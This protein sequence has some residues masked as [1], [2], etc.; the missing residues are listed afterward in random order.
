LGSAVVS[1]D[2]LFCGKR[3]QKTTADPTSKQKS[4]GTLLTPAGTLLTPAGTLLTTAGI[5]LTPTA[6]KSL[7][8]HYGRQSNLISGFLREGDAGLRHDVRLERKE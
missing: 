4:A 7:L 2:F 5:L 1:A 6:N 3:K 8:V